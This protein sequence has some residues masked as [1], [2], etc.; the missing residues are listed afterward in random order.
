ML[1]NLFKYKCTAHSSSSHSQH[2]L[3]NNK[4]TDAFASVFCWLLS[5][6]GR[7]RTCNKSLEGSRYIH[8]T[9]GAYL[10]YHII[11]RPFTRHKT[12]YNASDNQTL[13]LSAVSLYHSE[14]DGLHGSALYPF[15]YRG[16]FTLSYYQKTVHS[17]QNLLQCV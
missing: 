13:C 11:K 6:P 4:K 8:L 15:N 2:D 9:T 10:L 5:A 3:R 16:I 12:Y 7:N 17:S 14:S 1:R